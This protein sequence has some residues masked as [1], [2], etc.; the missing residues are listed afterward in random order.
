MYRKTLLFLSAI[1]LT[2]CGCSGSTWLGGGHPTDLGYGFTLHVDKT[3]KEN[4]S[5][6]GKLR[7]N[8]NGIGFSLNKV[9]N[10]D[11]FQFNVFCDNNLEQEEGE[12]FYLLLCTRTCTDR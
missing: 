2:S 12:T 1:F 10:K 9:H 3:Q 5:S 11:A 4:N 7:L 6:L 8:Y